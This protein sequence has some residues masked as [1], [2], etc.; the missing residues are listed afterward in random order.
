MILETWGAEDLPVDLSSHHIWV[1]L[2][3][4]ILLMKLWMFQW[5]IAYHIT[6]E[7]QWTLSLLWLRYDLCSVYISV[8]SGQDSRLEYQEYYG[9][10]PEIQY[11]VNTKVGPLSLLHREFQSCQLFS[12]FL[13][14][15]MSP[16]QCEL[17]SCVFLAIRTLATVWF[18]PKELIQI[19]GLFK[20]NPGLFS[21]FP[22]LFSSKF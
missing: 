13:P 10:Q 4:N 22:G 7:F 15:M 18:P 16:G 6:L 3:K 2:V 20:L 9:R 5:C 1:A 12:C 21:L 17:P 14:K 8:L 19:P 11:R